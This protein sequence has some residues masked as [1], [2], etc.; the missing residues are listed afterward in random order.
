MVK[1]LGILKENDNILE[2]VIQ[3]TQ[4]N[5]ILAVFVSLNIVLD[6]R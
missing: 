5:Q 3:E 1:I 2:M 6:S 4:F